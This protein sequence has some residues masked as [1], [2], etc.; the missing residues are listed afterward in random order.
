MLVLL[1]SGC[2]KRDTAD[3]PAHREIY[4]RGD[5]VLAEQSAAQFFEGR[6]L[7][8]DGDRLRVQAI[9]GN[10]SLNVVAS[11]VYRLP[12]AAHELTANMLAICARGEVWLPC[13][14]T[15]ISGGALQARSAGGDE[16][17]LSREHVLVP[18][19]LTELNLKRYFSRIEAEQSF[20]HAAERAGDP[21]PEPGWRPALRER[22]LVKV[23]AEWFTGYVREIDGDTA[24]V[25]LSSQRSVTVPLSALSA[26]PPSSFVGELRRGDFVLFRPDTPAQ[27]WARVQVRAVNGT[28]LKLG[29]A[30]GVSKSATVREV[31][32]LRP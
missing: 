23:G 21:R 31:I 20:A 14:V 16:F 30:S 10:D 15:K 4:V 12:P 32:P 18:S 19:A 29:D 27:A 22:L 17:D 9:G 5:R 28:E 24:Q 25:T 13:R 26:E 6:V 11:D 3:N 8:A 2:K 1:L 7:A